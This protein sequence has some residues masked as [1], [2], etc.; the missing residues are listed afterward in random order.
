MSTICP[1]LLLGN[2]VI[3]ENLRMQPKKFLDIPLMV[4]IHKKNDRLGVVF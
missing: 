2:T 1:R 3:Y 4:N